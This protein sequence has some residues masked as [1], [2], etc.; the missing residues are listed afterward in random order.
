MFQKENTQEVLLNNK[1]KRQSE[2]DINESG[3]KIKQSIIEDKSSN[4][5]NLDLNEINLIDDVIK[6]QLNI[7]GINN[8]KN[9]LSNNND[10]TKDN[11]A[12]KVKYEFFKKVSSIQRVNS[13]NN[14]NEE[15]NNSIDNNK[16]KLLINKIHY[17][18]K[19]EK[20]N[21]LLKSH[22]DLQREKSL[23][24]FNVRHKEK[25]IPRTKETEDIYKTK[26]VNIN[27][28]VNLKLDKNETSLFK[29]I[30]YV[31]PDKDI[32]HLKWKESKE[33]NIQEKISYIYDNREKAFN[34]MVIFDFNDLKDNVNNIKKKKK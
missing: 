22:G 30:K 8:I 15:K 4:N 11:I 24:K 27:Q 34:E 5:T 28:F 21:I 1:R 29:Y 25:Y 26:V 14:I 2:N 18:L 7:N 17:K 33:T 16:D 6:E 20:E 19:E 9:S 31:P 13:F 32:S 3:S 10:T 12:K 23:I